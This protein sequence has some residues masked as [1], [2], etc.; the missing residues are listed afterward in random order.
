M[1]GVAAM[2]QE[3]LKFSK[4]QRSSLIPNPTSG[5]FVLVFL[6]S[7]VV[8]SRAPAIAATAARE[9]ANFNIV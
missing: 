6:P 2:H 4:M 1:G 7:A 8:T 5:Y 9:L 3:S